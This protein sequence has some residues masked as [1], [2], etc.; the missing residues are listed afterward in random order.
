MRISRMESAMDGLVSP[1]SSL[2]SNRWIRSSSA[3]YWVRSSSTLLSV[4]GAISGEW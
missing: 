3:W 1:V 4:M 2:C